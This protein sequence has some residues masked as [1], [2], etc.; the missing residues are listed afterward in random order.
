MNLRDKARAIYQKAVDAARPQF[1]EE[2][3]RLIGGL[4]SIDRHLIDV[5]KV[6]R[7]FIYGSGKAA[8]PMAG[9]WVCPNTGH[10]VNLEEPARFN[11]E[12]QDFFSAAERGTWRGETEKTNG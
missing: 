9:L 4:L 8:I 7:F 5:S 2:R 12:L 3:V 10:A 6:N 1:L 11:A